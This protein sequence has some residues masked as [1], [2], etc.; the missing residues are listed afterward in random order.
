MIHQDRPLGAYIIAFSYILV[1]T[2]TM[3]SV[4]LNLIS[5]LQGTYIG[6][7]TGMISILSIIIYNKYFYENILKGM[8]KEVEK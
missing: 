3:V 5:E 2:I 7:G 4:Y 8:R 1:I 6:F